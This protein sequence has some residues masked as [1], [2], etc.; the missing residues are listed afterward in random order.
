MTVVIKDFL[1]IPVTRALP[2]QLQRPDKTAPLWA[3]MLF[4]TLPDL[5]IKWN[6]PTKIVTIFVG[7]WTSK[8][9]TNNDM[10]Y[11]ISNRY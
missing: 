2:S 5:L 7:Q 9:C 3:S 1:F 6:F 11:P 10:Q 8:T 4:S